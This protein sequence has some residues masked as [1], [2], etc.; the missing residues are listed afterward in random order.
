MLI[1]Q[2]VIILCLL[3]LFFWSCI[4]S[5]HDYYYGCGRRDYLFMNI[6]DISLFQ[7]N[8][9]LLP[10]IVSY[11]AFHI[12]SFFVFFATW[13]TRISDM[14]IHIIHGLMDNYRQPSATPLGDVGFRGRV[15]IQR[16][17][18]STFSPHC[19]ATGLPLRL[20][21]CPGGP[22]LFRAPDR[23]ERNGWHDSLLCLY[24]YKYTRTHTYLHTYI[25]MYVLN[26]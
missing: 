10:I 14:N 13:I 2:K 5:R 20:R 9:F 1:Y 7:S 6:H 11:F 3:F 18:T 15:G 19:T 22:G 23:W 16:G 12:V 17:M 21:L 24:T 8:L 25:R 26:R 4:I